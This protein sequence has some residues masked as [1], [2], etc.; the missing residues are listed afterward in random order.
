MALFDKGKNKNY[1][2]SG[3]V[4]SF[5]QLDFA[6]TEAYKLLRTNL[7]FTLPDASKKC[8]VIGITSSSRGEGKSTT[9]IN[10]SS[11]LAAT[12]KKV[13]LIDGDLRLPT[14]SKKLNISVK[15][16]LSDVLLDASELEMAIHAMEECENLHIL[17]SGK[18]PPNP[19]ELLGSSQ[20]KVLLEKL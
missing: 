1:S 4:K 3:E 2:E 18:I 19:S 13:L 16:G 17:A 10:L 5:D 15:T 20:M 11:A 12:E 14:I 6:S 8:H 7:Q 9:S